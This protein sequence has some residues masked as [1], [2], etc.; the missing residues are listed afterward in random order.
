MRDGGRRQRRRRYPRGRRRRRDRACSCRY[1]A[2]DPAGFTAALAARI[3][4]LLADPERA[5]ELGAAGRRRVLEEFSW[6]SIAE[7]TAALYERAG[8]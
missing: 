5:R 7:R 4:E 3:N 1:D 8:G 6:R 2:D